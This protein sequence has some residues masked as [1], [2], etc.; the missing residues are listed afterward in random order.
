MKIDL[1]PIGYVRNEHPHGTKPLTWQGTTS[2]IEFEP[3]W[4]NALSGLSGFS[5][6]IV[7]CYLHLIEDGSPTLIRPQR[8]PEMPLIGF[9][10]TRTPARPNP[11]SVTVV[12]LDRIDGSTLHVRNLDM[13]NGTPVL[14][15]KPYLVRGD[16]QP[17]AKEPQWIHHLR[18]IQD[19]RRQ[20]AKLED[21][22]RRGAQKS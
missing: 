2:R 14:D 3:R 9:F 8:N 4:A 22:Q 20:R 7:L 12:V 1:E 13:Y 19:A 15:V 5:H 6:I 11:I 21:A 10:G 16:C 18:E 17:E